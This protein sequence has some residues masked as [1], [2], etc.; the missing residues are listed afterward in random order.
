MSQRTGNGYARHL[1]LPLILALAA[2]SADSKP[3]SREEEAMKD[4]EAVID[5]VE[6]MSAAMERGSLED[7]LRYYEPNAT[8]VAQPGV[9]VSGAAFHEA[10]RGFVAMKPKFEMPN[11]EVI[12]SGDIALHLSPWTM[13]AVDPATGKPVRQSGLSLAVFRR[14]KDG[15][16]LMVIDNP[17]GGRLLAQ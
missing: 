7:A 15:K 17:F 4:S 9:N 5:A 1:I 16:W 6:G 3:R 12:Q 11:H 14:Q 13:E 8:L 2:V 10:M